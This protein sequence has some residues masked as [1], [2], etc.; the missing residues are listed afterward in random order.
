MSI[1]NVVL[2][3]LFSKNGMCYLFHIPK[4][5]KRIN[6]MAS[7][8]IHMLYFGGILIKF[9]IYPKLHKVQKCCF[10]LDILLLPVESQMTFYCYNIPSKKGNYLIIVFTS[11][12]SQKLFLIFFTFN[13]L[14][15]RNYPILHN[16][17]PIILISSYF[18]QKDVIE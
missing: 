10:K 6:H 11:A 15:I 14:T 12:F 18:C 3:Q 8:P 13:I 7:R 5:S 4:D 16:F 17:H 2:E 1:R 9:N